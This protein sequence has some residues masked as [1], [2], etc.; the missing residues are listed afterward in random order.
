MKMKV[1]MVSLI[2][3]LLVAMSGCTEPAE[4]EDLVTTTDLSV[5][6]VV[7]ENIPEGFEYLGVHSVDIEDVKADY[8][9]VDGIVQASEGIYQLDSVDHY[10]IA[11]ELDSP[12]AAEELVTQYKSSFPS[13]VI[14]RFED[15]SFNGHDAT[16][17]TK[18]ITLNGEQ[19]PRY[20]YIWTNENFVFVVRG[21]TEDSATLLELAKATGF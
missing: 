21:S 13:A 12:E 5:D 11:I 18:H 10:I 8:A 7:L 4:P 14:G 20:H 6:G 3:L 1:L 2:A 15:E 17:I 19:V 9:D 16:L